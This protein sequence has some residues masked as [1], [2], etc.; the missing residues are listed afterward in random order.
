M[1]NIGLALALG[2]ILYPVPVEK[3]VIKF[4]YW[5]MLG[6]GIIFYFVTHNSFIG[7]LEG[8]ILL[9]LFISYIGFLI[10]RQSRAGFKLKE[11]NK[12]E[13]WTIGVF[14]FSSNPKDNLPHKIFHS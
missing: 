3:E 12:K 14:N 6:A 5:V 2:A 1:A 7:Q 11:Y 9:V 10:A 4:D 13:S 8:I